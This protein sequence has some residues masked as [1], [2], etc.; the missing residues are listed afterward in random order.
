MTRKCFYCDGS[1]AVEDYIDVDATTDAPCGECD[2]TG[3]ACRRAGGRYT[4]TPYRI[5]NV[6]GWHATGDIL[7]VLAMLRRLRQQHA[8][9]WK[10][11]H[12]RDVYS[13]YREQAMKPAT[14]PKPATHVH[15]IFADL[16]RSLGLAA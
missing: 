9:D 5:Y 1:G 6:G 11:Y 8:G 13:H 4:G 3:D 15:P 10:G 2:G 16:F 7:E 14:L 12:A